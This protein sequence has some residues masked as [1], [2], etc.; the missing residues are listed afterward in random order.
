M[1]IAIEGNIGA[2]K[3]TLQKLLIDQLNGTSLVQDFQ[4]HP[5]LNDAYNHPEKFNLE[6]EMIFMYITYHQLKHLNSG[7]HLIISDF[8]FDRLKIFAQSFLSVSQLENLFYPSYDFL[9]DELPKPDLVI[10]LHGSPDL[11]LSRVKNRGREM[12]QGITVDY[13]AKLNKEFENIF[14]NI[15]YPVLKFNIEKYDFLNNN[16][17]LKELTSDIENKIASFKESINEF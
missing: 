6:K 13:L 10:W 12:E 16:N 14:A 17:H 7:D 11:L 2:G 4:A 15:N 8:I 3:S 1:L 5:Y 9:I